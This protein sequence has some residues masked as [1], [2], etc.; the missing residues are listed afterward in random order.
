M[1]ETK[2]M[3]CGA[4]GATGFYVEADNDEFPTVLVFECLGCNSTTP[5]TISTPKMKRSWGEDSDGVTC[6]L[7]G[8]KPES[9]TLLKGANMDKKLEYKIRDN[10][11]EAL[12]DFDFEKVHNT[13]NYLDWHWGGDNHAP[14]LVQMI[15][16]VKELFE[17]AM[18]DFKE[19]VCT[20][21]GG[22][23]VRIYEKGRVEIQFVVTESYSSDEEY[24]F[25]HEE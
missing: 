25:I 11:S 19:T 17:C 13:M 8:K 15:E 1:K 14:S 9:T 23:R 21:S 24:D 18:N 6:F 22:F 2:R 10:F 4:C 7:E 20:S 16:L 5:Y 3:S 12:E